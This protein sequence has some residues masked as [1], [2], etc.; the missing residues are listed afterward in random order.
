MSI[1]NII[2]RKPKKADNNTYVCQILDSNKESFR[3]KLDNMVVIQIKKY[4]DQFFLYMKNKSVYN[5]FYDIN[6]RIIDVV[7]EH[8]GEWF[9]NNM[10]IDYIDDYYTNTLIYDKK[11][12][13]LIKILITD[14]TNIIEN[15]KSNMVIKLQQLRF[16][17]QKFILECSIESFEVMESNIIDNDDNDEFFE[18]DEVPLPSFEEINIIK[19]DSINKLNYKISNIKSL[20]ENN[21]KDLNKLENYLNEL[22]NSINLESILKVCDNLEFLNE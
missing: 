16:F 8:C 12:G 13:D 15:V 14:K 18:E 21:N 9:N 2:I 1:D 5:K 7:K 3:L 17:K 11:Y 19:N 4:N 20:I 6:T 22:N 10:N